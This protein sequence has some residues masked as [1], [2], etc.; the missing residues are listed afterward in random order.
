[1]R[2]HGTAG[3]V[4]NTYPGLVSSFLL[5]IWNP[6]DQPFQK[7][8]G[9]LKDCHPKY[10]NPCAR[11]RVFTV[12]GTILIYYSYIVNCDILWCI[13][14][15]N[16]LLSVSNQQTWHCY[17]LCHQSKEYSPIYILTEP[18]I[19]LLGTRSCCTKEII[20]LSRVGGRLP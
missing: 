7:L 9:I 2:N 19:T 8:F 10:T 6:M 5:L 12:V 16:R 3:I 11:G 18:P 20:S 13:L 1:M 15:Y 17:R 4:P 14:M